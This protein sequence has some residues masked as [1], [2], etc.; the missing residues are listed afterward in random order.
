[1]HR[2]V[3]KA[4]PSRSIPAKF[5]VTEGHRNQQIDLLPIWLPINVP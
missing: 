5:K 4:D 3:L 2:S 1:V